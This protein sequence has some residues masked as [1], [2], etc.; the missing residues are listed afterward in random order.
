M[1]EARQSILLNGIEVPSQWNVGGF[2][3]EIATLTG[4]RLDQRAGV[5]DGLAGRA[6]LTLPCAQPP[7][8]T[9]T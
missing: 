3:L 9:M 2:D 6:W 1:L 5:I 4:G 8:Y 7:A